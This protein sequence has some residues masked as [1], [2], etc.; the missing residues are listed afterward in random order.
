MTKRIIVASNNPVKVQAVE[1]G[2]SSMFPVEVFEVEALGVTSGVSDQPMTSAETLQGARQ[3]AENARQK[4]PR[5]DYWAGVEGGVEEEGEGLAVFAWI[6]V[7]TDTGV[8]MARTGTFYLP[9]RVAELVR[10]GR[11]LGEAD[12]IVFGRTN[13][14]Q[15]N[16]AIGILTDN[17]IDRAR[18]YEQAVIMALIPF[19]NPA[20]Y[21]KQDR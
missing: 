17:A 16:G 18:Y 12:D 20:L 2:F 3:R 8:G 13:S 10:E 1:K 21:Q 14:K 7:L 5:A 15:K 9:P 4:S 19:K 11:E 6:V